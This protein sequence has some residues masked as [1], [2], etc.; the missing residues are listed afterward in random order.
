LNP[1]IGRPPG[2]AMSA[3]GTSWAEELDVA[4]E[5]AREASQLLLRKYGRVRV[6]YKADRSIV[7]AADMGAE[8]AIRSII[9]RHFRYDAYLGEEMGSR[10]GGSGRTWVVDPL[11]G[12]TN[13]SI[14]NPFFATSIALVEGDEPVL[15]VVNYPCQGE[16]FIARREMGAHL[17]GNGIG[18][19]HSRNLR[20][21]TLTFCHGP[22]PSSIARISRI[23]RRL[24][25]VTSRTRQMGAASLELCFTACGRVDAFLM[26][27][28]NSWDVAA[29][30]LMVEEA[31]GRV[32]DLSGDKFTLSSSS[33]L[34]SN[35]RIHRKLLKLLA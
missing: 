24:K 8:R 6:H 26:V 3:S 22:D 32:T 1:R 25:E 27:G 20:L 5:A 15:G 19:S 16:L 23:F 28:V 31:G 18:V 35:G 21:A 10:K 30:A 11:D 29:G 17:N 14:G 9:R 2:P 13:Y 7:T 12:S 34:A 33:L 4:T